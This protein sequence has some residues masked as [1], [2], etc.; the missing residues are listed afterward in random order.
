MAIAN[1]YGTEVPTNSD[2]HRQIWKVTHDGG[3]LLLPHRYRS[4]ISFSFGGKD[5]EEFDLI[6][7]CTGDT[8]SRSGSA[9]FEDLVTS[10]DI[11]DGQYYHG[12]HFQPNTLSL[13][14]VTDGID[15]Q[16][17]DNFLNWF[18]GGKIRELVL[19]EHPNRAIMARVS[20]PPELDVLPFEYPIVVNVG[21]VQYPTS[22]T[23]YKGT[24]SLELVADEPFWY[25]KQNF[26]RYGET[27][28]LGIFKDEKLIGGSKN[29]QE[30][31]KIVFEDHVPLS[32]M[33]QTTIHFG[34]DNFALL[35]DTLAFDKIA[36]PINA[37]AP[38]EKPSNWDTELKTKAGYFIETVVVNGVTQQ[39]YWK[40]A[41]TPANASDT[42]CIG[43]I[44]GSSTASENSLENVAL[45]TNDDNS[46]FFFYGGTAPSPAVIEFDIN[47]EPV[48][49]SP[50][51]N[52]IGNTYA[53]QNSVQDNE[54]STITIQSIHTKK[55]EFT[56]PNIITS[57]NKA[58]KIFAN[59]IVADKTQW[60][61]IADTLRDQIRH[62]A[63]RAWAVGIVTYLKDNPGN[64]EYVTAPGS[65]SLTQDI[66]VSNDG[67]EESVGLITDNFI[68]M[69]NSLLPKF[70][71]TRAGEWT[72]AH[73]KFDAE[74]GIARGKFSYWKDSSSSANIIADYMSNNGRAELKENQEED[75]GDMLRSGW[76]VIEDRNQLNS[77]LQV[78][79]YSSGHK[80]YA[81]MVKHNA[82][83]PLQG[84]KIKYKNRYL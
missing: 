77:E 55:F 34:E 6:A 74:L 70:F 43:I 44:A 39:Q 72:T 59:T 16:K 66:D 83:R 7:Y 45:S 49:D 69:A 29:F 2:A 21:G 26:L 71:Q 54:Y 4:F 10:Y 82:R 80:E 53:G 75:V 38:T 62:P 51:I 33:I 30:A 79:P 37:S 1:L 84:L 50:Y 35:D 46:Y 36:G 57:W 23:L 13:D 20:K 64:T 22:T 56:T 68:T 58:K 3:G 12:T 14:L 73:F 67:L 40:G 24:I 41:K 8:M 32:S 9:D 42:S 25:A 65:S 78:S 17:L 27:N 61:D 76:L 18:S 31:I 11:M 28:N 48:G 52:C 19:A 47:L 15:Q 5:I 60:G 81:H 63:V